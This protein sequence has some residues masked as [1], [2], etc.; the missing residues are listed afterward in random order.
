MNEYDSDRIIN[1]LD[2]ETTDKPENADVIIVNTCAIREKADQKALSSLGRYKNLKSE[3][4]DLVVGISG[5]V[6]QLYGDKL[7][8]R[9]PYLD[10]VLGPRA[11]PKL[12]QLIEDVR[13]KR[14]RPVETSFDI[15]E[16]F[17]IQPYHEQG[18]STAFVSVQ[19]GCNKRCTYCIV[20]TVRGSEVNRPL[21]D[22]IRESVYLLSKGVKEI[23][24]IGQTVNS[25]KY[26]NYK[27]GDLLHFLAELE[28]LE[29]I[30]FTTSYPRDITKKMINA[31]SDVN[32]VCH[33]LHLPVQSGSNKVL[34]LMNRTYTREW[35]L[36]SVARL[37]D[38][39]PDMALSSDIIV[40]FPG[41][42]EDD[43]DQT[44]TLMENV[45][46]ESSFS[47]KFSPRPGTIGE[48]LSKTNEMV[49]DIRAGE[50]LSRLQ[51]YQKE[52]TLKKNQE[53]VGKIEKVLVEGTSKHDPKWVMGR[54]DHNRIVNF[55]G[56]KS[57][58]GSIVDVKIKEGLANS[59]RGE[60]E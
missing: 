14:I 2:A 31:M 53:R 32:K 24:L 52:I 28:A 49:D 59:L 8:K 51:E 45:Q 55:P 36:D 15:E 30:R 29:R 25:W 17:E 42:S 22:I 12:P 38:A 46:F 54:T 11:I 26:D 7:L 41:E 48:K 27:F 44:M 58:I 40:G 33:H 37:K 23:T 56:K 10:F 4:P 1:A 5:C 35:Y 20:P 47:F 18:K 13:E 34:K 39:I 21:E 50:R 60:L 9:M 3:N 43:F 6:A 57:L 16:V 19:Q